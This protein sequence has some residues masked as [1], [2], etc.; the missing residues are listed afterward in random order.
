MQS[1]DT[2]RKTSVLEVAAAAAASD[3]SRS[4]DPE[5]EA[6]DADAKM[7][8]ADDASH[9][10]DSTESL[11]SQ[12]SMMK[13]VVDDAAKGGAT[14]VQEVSAGA[15]TSTSPSD[16]EVSRLIDAQL[17]PSSSN[18]GKD[19]AKE[20]NSITGADA[21]KPLPSFPAL[22]SGENET[23]V[24]TDNKSPSANQPMS[25]PTSTS[26]TTEAAETTGQEAA[27]NHQ[28]APPPSVAIAKRPKPGGAS[29]S[30]LRAANM[31][32]N[33]SRGDFGSSN[34]NT[35]NNTTNNTATAANSITPLRRGKWTVEE[36]EYAALVIQM[37]N[38][39]YLPA[40]AGT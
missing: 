26:S 12:E 9:M 37:F 18:D 3:T 17:G 13:V 36:E 23:P 11:K 24:A 4:R 16:E 28:T 15:A 33:P 5:A 1:S 6:A 35:T 10:S 20:T 2:S 21:S 25:P 31:P 7:A 38:A 34:S 8:S 32:N 30:K 39:G 40:P 14:S 22:P 27:T 19:E 29:S